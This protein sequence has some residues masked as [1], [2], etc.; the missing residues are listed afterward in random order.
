MSHFE[1]GSFHIAKEVVAVILHFK[2]QY[3]EHGFASC[4]GQCWCI[5]DFR[6]V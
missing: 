5:H 2:L 3:G 6:G 4:H 1:V